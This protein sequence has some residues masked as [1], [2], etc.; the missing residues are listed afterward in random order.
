[1]IKKIILG[2]AN[3]G[4][5]YGVINK[6]Y[7]DF[8]L[9]K[10]ILSIA[11]KNEIYYLD[12][13]PDYKN[14]EIILGNI[15]VKKFKISTKLL[16]PSEYNYD[17]K[18][19][20]HNNIN[21]SLRR[22][23]IEKLNILYFR[24]PISLLEGDNNKLWNYAKKLKKEGLIKNLGITLYDP[25]ELDLVFDDLRPDVV[26][27]PYNLFDQRFEKTNWLDKLYKHNVIVQCRS[28]FLQGL[29]F[30]NV[31]NIPQRFLKFRSFWEKYQ[32]WLKKNNLSILEANVNFISQNKKISNYL[33]GI[34]NIDQLLE[35]IN[36]KEKKIKHTDALS[37]S[38][39]DIIDPR[40]WN[41]N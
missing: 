2:T 1:M 21:A 3:F 13:A 8:N 14:S 39:K 36:V 35:I 12:T 19:F 15:G 28:I 34:E 9:A 22:L 11:S 32:I 38:K 27:V 10:K 40:L 26:Q 18:K 23:N 25:Q 29:L 37:T 5:S 33:V 7:I 31:N 41:K 24:R 20:F 16:P 6:N 4:S 17:F 30:C